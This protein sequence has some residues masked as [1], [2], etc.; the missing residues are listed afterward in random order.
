MEKDQLRIMTVIMK[1]REVLF[2]LAKKRKVNTDG[3]ILDMNL[4]QKGG[5]YSLS[6][7]KEEHFRR[8]SVHWKMEELFQA[9]ATSTNWTHFRQ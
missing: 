4:L 6:Y 8:K 2:N 5:I 3:L 7:I 1:Y 9:K